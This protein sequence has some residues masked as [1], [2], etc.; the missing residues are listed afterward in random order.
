MLNFLGKLFK[1]SDGIQLV[2]NKVIPHRD[3]KELFILRH[4][5][6][7]KEVFHELVRKFEESHRAFGLNTDLRIVHFW[8]QMA[9]ETGGFRWLRELGGRNYFKKYDGRRDLG[10]TKPGDG[11]KYRGR[12]IIHITGRHNYSVYS[13]KVG[14]DLVEKPEL[15]EEPDIAMLVAL[16]YWQDKGLNHLADEDNIKKITK[17]INGGYNGLKDREKYL[18]RLK[19]E[20]NII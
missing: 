19:A 2:P 18:K 10:N 7:N 17:R 13:Q 1:K 14:V 8:A 15:A 3:F 16:H 20:F 12:G 6:A 4:Q 5:G 11:Y 9:H